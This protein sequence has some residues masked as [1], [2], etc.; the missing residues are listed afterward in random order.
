MNVR[1]LVDR[2]AVGA[3]VYGV[4]AC[5]SA[6]TEWSTFFAFTKLSIYSV[7]RSPHSSP[8]PS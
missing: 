6:L 7:R 8:Q 5:L 4:V 2:Y 3:A 1:Q